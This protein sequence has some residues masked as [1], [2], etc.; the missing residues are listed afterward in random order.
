MGVGRTLGEFSFIGAD[1]V[2]TCQVIFA[3]TDDATMKL[4]TM[5]MYLLADILVVIGEHRKDVGMVCVVL[6]LLIFFCGED[7]CF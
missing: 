4:T 5:P 3:K 1:D 2:V 7:S 6:G